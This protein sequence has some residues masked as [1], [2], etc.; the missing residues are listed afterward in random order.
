MS[1]TIH[2]NLLGYSEIY[3][4]ILINQKIE[5]IESGWFNLIILGHWSVTQMR[6]LL[7]FSLLKN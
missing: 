5:W 2:N 7:L 6:F 3:K 1:I 4:K